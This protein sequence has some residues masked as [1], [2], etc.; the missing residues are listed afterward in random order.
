M[1]EWVG[2]AINQSVSRLLNKHFH[3]LR[4]E[5]S[6]HLKLVKIQFKSL[7]IDLKKTYHVT[8]CP[9]ETLPRANYLHWQRE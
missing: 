4:T 3:R 7:T 9:R 8:L 5:P 6:R 2:E 1:N